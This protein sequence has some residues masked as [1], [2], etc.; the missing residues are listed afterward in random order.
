[1]S[2]GCGLRG[3]ARNSRASPTGGGTGLA[4]GTGWLRVSW[5]GRS[6]GQ[7]GPWLRGTGC[8]VGGGHSVSGGGERGER[9]GR[10]SYV[11]VGQEG[12]RAF[13]EILSVHGRIRTPPGLH[14]SSTLSSRAVFS[15]P[16]MFR[17]AAQRAVAQKLA[18][19]AWRTSSLYARCQTTTCMP[20][21]SLS[22]PAFS[23]SYPQLLGRRRYADV[24]TKFTRTK[25]HMN[26]GTIGNFPSPLRQRV[27]TRSQAT[28][29]ME[30]RP[31]L[32][33]SPKFSQT[34]AQPSSQTTHRLTRLPRKRPVA[35]PLI[36]PM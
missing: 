16:V 2:G 18:P 13:E 3:D 6:R 19:P 10:E 33:P 7:R 27:L 30:R 31:S 14:F 1:M 25:P 9:R 32:P 26:I 35:S 8:A 15:A 23:F 11:W 4:G 24:A 36:L 17:L 21:P 29:T 28:S 34:R 12:D 5:P 22:V 20:S